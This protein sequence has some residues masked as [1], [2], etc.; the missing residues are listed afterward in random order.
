MKSLCEPEITKKAFP[1]QRFEM[2][3]GFLPE[4]VLRIE[5]PL[6]YRRIVP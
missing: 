6:F 5:K 1:H 2:L 4:P 3:E